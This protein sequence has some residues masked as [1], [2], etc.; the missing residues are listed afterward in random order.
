MEIKL[1]QMLTNDDHAKEDALDR[2]ECFGE[3]DKENRLCFRYCA[4]SIKCCLMH[5]LNPKVDVLEQLL[6]YNDYS[7][8]PN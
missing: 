4:V 3:F 7:V 1:D 5:S 8:K 6:T 2:P